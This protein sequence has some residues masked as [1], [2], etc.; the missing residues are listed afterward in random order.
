[1]SARGTPFILDRVLLTLACAGVA[2]VALGGFVNHAANRLADGV[3]LPLW[4]AP[5][6]DQALIAG[7]LA[8]MVAASCL[9]REKP[10]ALAAI[11]AAFAL[12]FGCLVASAHFADRLAEG[13]KPAAR[14]SLGAAF[15]ILIALAALCALN[16]AQRG[17]LPFALRVAIGAGFAAGFA[18]LAQAGVFAQ[19]ALARE[20]AVHRAE[21]MVQLWRHMA[22]VGASVAIA[23]AISIPLTVLAL[24][25]AHW[26][27]LLFA[28]LGVVQTIPSIALFGVLIAPLAALAG[29]FPLLGAWGVGGTGAAPAIIALTLY[30]LGP[31]VRIFVTGFNEVSADVKD[32]A[33]GIGFD[34]RRLFFAVE[35]PL[36]LPA[37]IS[38]L[39]VVAIQAIGLATVA[40]LIGAGGLGVFVFQGIGQ[41]AL[42]LVLLG[43]IPIIL[44]ALAADLVFSAGLS[45]ARGKR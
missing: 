29:R 23:L 13:A 36:A 19:L 10:R 30:S 12:F 44:M 18:A 14:T 8:A 26:R 25:R 39:R 35:F 5:P 27:G 43:A 41:Y 28:T 22:L 17:R 3:A 6:G 20:F 34:G 16:A 1:M 37:L 11:G 15:W 2:A 40:A 4:R 42:D 45:A 7:A 31:L 33:R 21:F 38:G 24:H 32:A 9:S